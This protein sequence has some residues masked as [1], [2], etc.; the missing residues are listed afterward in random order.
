MRISEYQKEYLSY[1]RV[2][3]GNCL[4]TIEKKRD[5]IRKII[6][7][8]R[9]ISVSE[10]N[11][12][13][14]LDLKGRLIDEGLSDS[15]MASLIS[16]LKDFLK[17]LK[18]FVELDGIYDYTKITIPRVRGK[19]TEYWMEREVDEFIEGL[20]EITLKD[21]RFKALCLLLAVSGARISEVLG[22]RR[23]INLGSHEAEVLGK[24]NRYRKV[25]WDDTT[26]YY[27]KQYQDVRPD[28]DKSPFL[29]GTI[30]KGNYSGQW[31]KGDINRTFRK[32]SKKIGKRI[33]CHKFRSS[34]LTNGLHNGINLSAISKAMGHSDIRTSMRYFAPMTDENTKA[35]FEKYFSRKK[36]IESKGN[37]RKI[38]S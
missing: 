22:L 4:G 7:S 30:N 38:T 1:C 5:C 35:E 16:T 33:H 23:D 20:P 24:G 14:Q 28:W 3:K 19:P 12:Y 13:I 17:Y 34:F 29:F 8:I 9:D 18:E 25:Y 32:I 27:L 21:K 37:I 15:R 10:I 11:Q 2:E 26:E 36:T 31:D 6:R